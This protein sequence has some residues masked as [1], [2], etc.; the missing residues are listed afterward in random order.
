MLNGDLSVLL[1]LRFLSSIPSRKSLISQRSALFL[2]MF[3]Y[4]VGLGRG[5]S[6]KEDLEGRQG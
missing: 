3:S 6:T 5:A 4:D 1:G 2:T